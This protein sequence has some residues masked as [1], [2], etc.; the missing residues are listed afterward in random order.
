MDDAVRIIF[1]ASERSKA[2]AE[3][4]VMVAKEGAIGAWTKT[5]FL[6]IEG[7]L[8]PVRQDWR[9][10]CHRSSRRQKIIAASVWKEASAAIA[11]CGVPDEAKARRA[12][13]TSRSIER[14]TAR[15]VERKWR[16]KSWTEAFRC[17]EKIPV[18]HPVNR[19]QTDARSCAAGR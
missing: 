3:F 13:L 2:T 6:Y 19:Y 15:G 10:W 16:P 1:A 12:L 5:A 4:C 14:Q 17:V 18:S 8:F 7:R 11:I 9:R